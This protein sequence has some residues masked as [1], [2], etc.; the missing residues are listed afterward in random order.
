MERAERG[1]L[2]ALATGEFH[3]SLAYLTVH[4]AASIHRNHNRNQMLPFYP[5]NFVEYS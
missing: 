1:V 4:L 5:V 3:D 2:T